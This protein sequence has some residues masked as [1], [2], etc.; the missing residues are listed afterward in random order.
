MSAYE[1]PPPEREQRRSGARGRHR[2]APAGEQD[3][4]GR[5]MVEPTPDVPEQSRQ[6]SGD[7]PFPVD[8]DDTLGDDADEFPDGDGFALRSGVPPRT[9]APSAS[10][11]PPSRRCSAFSMRPSPRRL[12]ATCPSPRPL[13][14]NER[15]RSS[16][17]PSRC[18][19]TP[20]AAPC[21][22]ARSTTPKSAAPTHRDAR[23][24]RLDALSDS[25]RGAFR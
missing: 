16:S 5:S 4:A 9:S 19:S 3:L 11:S 23:L 1:E 13:G 12:R 2:S 6:G 14:S 20:G 25:W 10:S 15:T 17:A 8:F 21:A 22:P 24:R 7:D 18:S